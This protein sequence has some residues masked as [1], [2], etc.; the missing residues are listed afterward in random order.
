VT[1]KWATL[2]GL[3]WHSFWAGK[4][5][6]SVIYMCRILSIFSIRGALFFNHHTPWETMPLL[7]TYLWIPMFANY[8]HYQDMITDQVN[9][10]NN[11]WESHIPVSDSSFWGI[12]PPITLLDIIP[13][14]TG[15]S[16]TCTKQTRFSQNAT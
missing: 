13:V 4:N 2:Y 6:Q 1:L 8:I 16:I 11:G 10:V 5:E 7:E 12:Y 3:N 15:S 9:I 14:S